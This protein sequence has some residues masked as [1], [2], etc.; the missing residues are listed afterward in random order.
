MK[1]AQ[2]QIWKKGDEYLRIVQ[3]ERLQVG[4][5]AIR[6]ITS[7][8]GRHHQVSKKEFCRLLKGASLLTESEVERIREEERDAA[9]LQDQAGMPSPAKAQPEDNVSGR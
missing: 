9:A 6:S 2:N 7:G 8:G 3:L 5:K 4:Y 1:L